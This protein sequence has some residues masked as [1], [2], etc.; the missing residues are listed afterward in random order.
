MT[1][2]KIPKPPAS[3]AVVMAAVVAEVLP[4]LAPGVVRIRWD[5]GEDWAGDRALSVRVLLADSVRS[6]TSGQ[7]LMQVSSQAQVEI[8]TRLEPWVSLY[9]FHTYYNYRTVSEQA[10]MKCPEWE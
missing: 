2:S 10:Q 8:D 4:L 5:E 6:D 7:S 1:R 9:R 3:L